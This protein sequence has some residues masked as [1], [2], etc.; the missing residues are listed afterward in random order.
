MPIP[1]KI[2]QDGLGTEGREWGIKKSTGIK[3]RVG[4]VFLNYFLDTLHYQLLKFSA[5][6]TWSLMGRIIW[7]CGLSSPAW[8]A[9]LPL[10]SVPVS[11]LFEDK[12]L[13]ILR[14][15]NLVRGNDRC[16]IETT[17]I[18]SQR[19]RLRKTLQQVIKNNSAPLE[20][21]SCLP[22][23]WPLWLGTAG[24]LASLSASSLW[25]ALAHCASGSLCPH[26][27]TPL[28]SCQDLVKGCRGALWSPSKHLGLRLGDWFIMMCT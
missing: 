15:S 13:H 10:E 7:R 19:A 25:L 20:T 14:L 23:P 16:R 4:N 3:R 9:S 8:Y 1:K 12:S 28:Q 24:L 2:V 27:W 21:V 6:K 11:T 17:H 22:S 18:Q 5:A 26:Y